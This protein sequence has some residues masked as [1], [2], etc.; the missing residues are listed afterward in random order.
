M[1]SLL[2][3]FPGFRFTNH[4]VRRSGLTK[5]LAHFIAR[6]IFTHANNFKPLRLIL[7]IKPGS[8]RRFVTPVAAP[9]REVDHHHQLLVLHSH[10]QIYWLVVLDVA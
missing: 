3:I 5:E 9:W 8:D 4:S 2:A 6:S 1:R 10:S 7:L